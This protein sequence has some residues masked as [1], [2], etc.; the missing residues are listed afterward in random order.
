M[1]GSGDPDAVVLDLDDG[2]VAVGV[3]R[4]GDAATFRSELQSVREKIVQHLSEAR[5]VADEAGDRR[6]RGDELDPARLR[7]RTKCLDRILHQPLEVDVLVLDCELPRIDLGKEQQIADKIEQPL[8]VSVDDTEEPL[9]FGSE[10]AA[11]LEQELEVSTDG[12]ERS[13]QL[14][15]HER[16]ELVLHQVELPEPRVLLGQQPLDHLG[17]GARRLLGLE[18]LLVLGGLF[19]QGPVS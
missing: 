5:P 15:R 10:V 12:G 9:L 8:G 6:D 1:L 2:V 4:D 14:V 19:P 16:D 7:D 17:L 11:L 3:Q 18:E 13:A